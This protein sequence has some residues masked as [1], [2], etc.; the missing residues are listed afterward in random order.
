MIG[1]LGSSL[2]S[3][4]AKKLILRRMDTR[5]L[6]ADSSCPLESTNSPKTLRSGVLCGLGENKLVGDAVGEDGGEAGGLLD[7]GKLAEGMGKMIELKPPLLLM[8]T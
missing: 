7:D 6:L 5:P 8:D 3:L 4:A 2:P 1:V